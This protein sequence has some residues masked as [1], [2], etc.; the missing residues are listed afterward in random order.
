MSVG[1]F[2]SD[3]VMD[4]T[5]ANIMSGSQSLKI[6][7]AA[8]SGTKIVT[9]VFPVQE[10]KL[11]TARV[12]YKN[13]GAVGFTASV[14]YYEEDRTTQVDAA[15]ARD[16]ILK[17]TAWTTYTLETHTL[18]SPSGARYA[19]ITMTKTNANAQDIWVDKIE[20][21]PAGMAL[22][23]QVKAIADTATTGTETVP[24][25][26]TVPTAAEGKNFI[27]NTYTPRKI[28]NRM[29][30]SICL[31]IRASAAC[32]LL[33]FITKASGS[34]VAATGQDVGA[35]E[36]CTLRVEYE[37]EVTSLSATSWEGRCGQSAA[38]TMTRNGIAGARYWGGAMQT[39]I[40]I[41]EWEPL[42]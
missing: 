8:G 14:E 35:G 20:F 38:G 13:G 3:V 22:V 30:V 2:G 28:G 16:I 33:A 29:R 6:A 25:D 41:E 5:S 15:T 27:S 7:A 37:E 19:R 1:S 10:A 23:R 9:D 34:A 18:V 17:T 4:T 36:G 11:Y 26:D 40:E 12:T 39:Y 32:F 31:N 21:N 24:V 42:V